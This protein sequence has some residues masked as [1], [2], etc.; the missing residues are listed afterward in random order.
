MTLSG[1]LHQPWISILPFSPQFKTQMDINQI[2][3]KL[4][5][6]GLIKNLYLTRKLILK[7]SNSPH[8]PLIQF[9]K[10]LFFSSQAFDDSRNKADP[11]I[12]N[13]VVKIYSHGSD[14]ENA[15]KVFV[16]MLESGVLVDEYSL[17]LVLKACSRVGLVKNGMQIHG[18]LKK[19]EFGSDLFLGNCLISMYV[20]CGCIEYGR[21]FFD[22]MADKDSVSYNSMIDGYVKCGMVD[23]ARQ[24]FHSLPAGMRNLI[25][26]NTMIGGFVKLGDGFESAWELF[27]KMPERDVVSWNMMIDCC[28][29][30]GK[31]RMAQMLFD[32]MPRRDV[33]SWAIMIDGYAKSGSVDVARGFFDD[34][35]V[36]DVISCNAM[37]A[38]Y[39]R[40]GSYVEALKM[41]H[42]VLNNSDF[43]PDKTTFLI[44]LSAAAHL[45]NI[46]EGVTIHSHMKNNGLFA[47]G[48]LG[49][50]LIDMYAKCGDIDCALSVFEDIKEKSVDH[51]NAMIGGLAI[52]GLGEL[53]FD[54]FMEMERRCIE[55]DD[56]TFIALLNACGHAGMLKEGIIC[57]EILRRVHNMDPKLQH[58]GCIVDILSRAG[59]IEEARTFVKEMPIEPNTVILRTLLGA[60]K[61]HENLSTG[62]PLAQHL[63]GLNS[64][65]SSSYV[66][67]SNIYAQLGL[68]DSV[69]CIRTIM[70]AKNVKKFPGCSWIELEG[71]VH[72]FFVGDTSHFQVKEIFSTLNR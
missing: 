21:Q 69:R 15:L 2:H 3:A 40:N 20:K 4:L 66:L 11:L 41:Y 65:N 72:E 25:T 67:L 16:L 37:M 64:L 44:A 52:N 9:A 50:A 12:W 10:Y 31:M 70:K 29:K 35:P 60:C 38:G 27:E 49:V 53:A 61:N 19:C 13:S 24:L 39:L 32:T 8:K 22:R 14:P 30:S 23:F 36:R 6:T 18:L 46:N 59:H 58:Y 56:I 54:M 62:E 34:M 51:W 33:A 57:F 26:W 5:T 63:I 42:D 71:L 47:A 55:P 48:K 45:G 7:F 1:N 28:I 43:E 17:S 68:W